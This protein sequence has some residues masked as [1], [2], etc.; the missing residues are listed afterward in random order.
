MSDDSEKRWAKY[1]LASDNYVS[2]MEI[3]YD[4]LIRIFHYQLDPLIVKFKDDD[5][6]VAFK[7]DIDDIFAK[8]KDSANDLLFQFIAQK[9]VLTNKHKEDLKIEYGKIFRK[10]YGVL[11]ADKEGKND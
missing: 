6:I 1:K 5:D 11:E 8:F 3:S 2:I 7:K 4:D 9:K 10:A